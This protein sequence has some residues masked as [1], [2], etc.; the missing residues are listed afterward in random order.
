MTKN[1]LIYD[2]GVLPI[3]KTIKDIKKEF[4]EHNIVMWASSAHQNKAGKNLQSNRPIVMD[5]ETLDLVNEGI[6]F[7]DIS[8]SV[9]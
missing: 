5:K 2:I 9:G 3:G 7:V 4:E 8:E 1:I 6:K